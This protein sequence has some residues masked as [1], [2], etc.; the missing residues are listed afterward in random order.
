M[1]CVFDQLWLVSRRN[2]LDYDAQPVEKISDIESLNIYPEMIRVK[3]GKVHYDISM[4][5]VIKHND[6]AL[7]DY[8][9]KHAVE[10]PAGVDPDHFPKELQDEIDKHD[11]KFE[12]LYNI[13]EAI[14]ACAESE[15]EAFTVEL[16]EE[17][18]MYKP[19]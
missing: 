12:E 2:T 8:Q 15:R 7:A 10:I 1:K 16:D 9:G 5:E 19:C 14:Y 6:D 11:A 4:E 17:T 3:K 18:N 13:T